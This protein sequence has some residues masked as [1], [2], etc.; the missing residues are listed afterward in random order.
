MDSVFRTPQVHLIGELVGAEGFNTNKVY[1]RWEINVGT[2]WRLLA[3]IDQGETFYDSSEHSQDIAVFEHPVDL[4]YACK[5]L[6]G[7]PRLVVEVWG[8]DVHGRH[9]VAG[10]GAIAIPCAPGEYSLKV[11]TW[12]PQ[13]TAEH[14]R[15]SYYLGA[16]P[17]L[18]HKKMLLSGNARFGLST[19]SSGTV[20]LRIGVIVKDFHLHGIIM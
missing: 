8:V 15:L 11:P 13:G 19:V 2:D 16:N 18:V 12:R 3:G 17:E 14:K 4:H 10:Y 1:A 9:A 6:T 20:L 7:W 5:S